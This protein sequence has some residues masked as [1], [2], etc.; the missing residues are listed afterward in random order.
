M[1]TSG[2]GR[3]RGRGKSSVNLP[4]PS[5][6]V[7]DTSSGITT[8]S[9]ETA[10]PLLATIPSPVTALDIA[11]DENPSSTGISSVSSDAPSPIVPE[12]TSTTS[13]GRGRGA[14]FKS[15][16][17]P[18]PPSLS[19]ATPTPAEPT[20]TPDPYWTVSDLTNSQF[21]STARAPKPD[22]LGQ[23]GREIQVIANYFPI[24]QFPRYGLVYR[25][26]IQMRNRKD[27]E[28]HRDLR[29]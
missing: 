26:H 2:A 22:E 25:Y 9:S 21:Y 8:S 28:L 18:P 20:D 7:S 10:A 4:A 17:P 23:I 11:Q 29:R 24:L 12:P 13:K 19:S 3:G 16:Q 6:P 15:D 14:R 27:E 5:T 1:A